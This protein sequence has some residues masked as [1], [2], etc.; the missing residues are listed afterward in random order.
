MP[1]RSHLPIDEA[2]QPLGAPQALCWWT[3]LP[4]RA[5]FASSALP[6]AV[7][8]HVHPLDDPTPGPLHWLC[9][10]PRTLFP[11]CL[12]G[13]CPHFSSGFQQERAFLSKKKKT[14]KDIHLFILFGFLRSQLQPERSLLHHAGFFLAVYE[15]SGC[16]TQASFLHG[17][18]DLT[19]PTKD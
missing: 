6:P 2:A 11:R 14:L 12:H 1:C 19:S 5:P 13:P 9:L 17:V 18:W 8:S 7:C 10:L 16:G 15:L 3:L 4:I